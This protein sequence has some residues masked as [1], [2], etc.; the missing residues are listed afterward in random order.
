MSFSPAAPSVARRFRPDGTIEREIS[1]P[2]PNVTCLAFGGP[3]LNELYITTARQDMSPAELERVPE[4]GG[5]YRATPV[6]VRGLPDTLF[7]D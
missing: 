7:A 6:G 2:A 3:D 5:V 1:V 4:I